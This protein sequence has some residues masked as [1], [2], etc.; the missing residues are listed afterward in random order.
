M[1]GRILRIYRTRVLVLALLVVIT[2]AVSGMLL[3]PSEQ[4]GRSV[5]GALVG[6]PIDYEPFVPP[7]PPS[8]PVFVYETRFVL[9]YKGETKTAVWRDVCTVR[10]S[11]A[12]AWYIRF[13]SGSP[14]NPRYTADVQGYRR[15][16]NHALP[17]L[18]R[19]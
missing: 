6:L 13:S 3:W 18:R 17:S 12:P 8:P 1:L 7:P 14:G 15:M 11:K 16:R 9:T 10:P 19:Y 2:G 5:G 4:E